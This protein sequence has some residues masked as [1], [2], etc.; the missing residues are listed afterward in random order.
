MKVKN[1]LNDK[2]LR[3]PGD[4]DRYHLEGEL[5]TLILGHGDY[6]EDVDNVWRWYELAQLPREIFFE[7]RFEY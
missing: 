6:A 1:L 7:L 5:A 2:W 4:L 3:L